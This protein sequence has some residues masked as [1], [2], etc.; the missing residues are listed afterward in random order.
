M[1]R[2][3]WRT[4]PRPA[5]SHSRR[6]SSS[7]SSVSISRGPAPDLLYRFLRWYPYTGNGEHDPPGVVGWAPNTGNPIGRGFDD[8]VHLFGGVTDQGGFGHT[9]FVVNRAGDLRWFHYRGGANGTRPARAGSSPA[10]G[11]SSAP[12]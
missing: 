8:V 9:M 4:S 12:A 3:V 1:T 6:I 5:V 11:T 2:L 7:S 10:R